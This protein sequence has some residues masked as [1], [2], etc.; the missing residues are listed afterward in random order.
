MKRK[1]KTMKLKNKK[2]LGGFFS[3]FFSSNKTTPTYNPGNNTGR[4]RS[5]YNSIKNIPSRIHNSLEEGA[6]RVNRKHLERIQREEEKKR[7][8]D[9]EEYRR[10]RAANAE[11]QRLSFDSIPTDYVFD[12]NGAVSLRSPDVNTRS[13]Y[14]KNIAV[15][16]LRN[17]DSRKR[18][19]GFGKNKTYK[20]RRQ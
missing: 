6:E 16:N 3:N 15:R 8:K 12:E 17:R 13:Q 5:M 4:F 11:R 19:G 10:I 9:E 14:D 20:K 1:T 7:L 18:Y 2:K